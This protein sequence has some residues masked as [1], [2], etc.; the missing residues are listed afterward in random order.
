L[1]IQDESI[2]IANDI[3]RNTKGGNKSLDA[4]TVLTAFKNECDSVENIRT[5]SGQKS[6]IKTPRKV[7]D[8]GNQIKSK[9]LGDDYI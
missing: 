8:M 5:H 2:K 3:G 1:E 7:S 6:N 4:Q 9:K